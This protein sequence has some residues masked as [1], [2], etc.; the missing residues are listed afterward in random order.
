MGSIEGRLKRLEDKLYVADNRDAV[1]IKI[2]PVVGEYQRVSI[3][4]NN[5]IAIHRKRGETEDQL[6][7]RAE[8]EIRALTDSKR[9]IIMMIADDG[10]D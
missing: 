6:F 2:V 3:L 1:V 9:V 5:N 4:E 8:S 7:K 10:E